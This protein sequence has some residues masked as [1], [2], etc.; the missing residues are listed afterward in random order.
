L[1]FWVYALIDEP[2]KEEKLLAQQCATF[3]AK[4][5][6]DLPAHRNS[7][8]SP[9]GKTYAMR[10]A[11]Y[12]L[13]VFVSFGLESKAERERLREAARQAF[14]QF[15]QLRAVSLEFYAAHQISG[16]A[17]FLSREAITPPTPTSS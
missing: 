2:S 15:P 10:A 4:A 16:R 9:G 13:V 6:G 5:Y 11:R 12:G 14:S 3:I 17:R 7:N 8:P 1:A